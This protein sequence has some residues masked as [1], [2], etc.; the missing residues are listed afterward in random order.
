MKTNGETESQRW[1]STRTELTNLF[2]QRIEFLNKWTD[3]GMIAFFR[4]KSSF[5]GPIPISPTLLNFRIQEALNT[6]GSMSCNQWNDPG[7]EICLDARWRPAIST[8]KLSWL[9]SVTVREKNSWADGGHLF[10]S[11]HVT[12]QRRQYQQIF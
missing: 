4:D 8:R 5:M 9:Y 12:S 11:K 10:R 7:L 1:I 3:Y 6:V 2:R